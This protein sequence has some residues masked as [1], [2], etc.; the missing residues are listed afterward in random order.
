MKPAGFP[1]IFKDMRWGIF[2][3]VALAGSACTLLVDTS[4]LANGAGTTDGGPEAAATVDPLHDAGSEADVFADAEAPPACPPDALLCEDFENGLG[5]FE[6]H[7]DNG[8]VELATDI[9]HGGKTA[10]RATSNARDGGSNQAELRFNLPKAIANGDTVYFRV[11]VYFPTPLV[12]ESTISK[13]RTPSGTSTDDIN[14]KIDTQGHFKIDADNAKEGP[15]L[16]GVNVAPLARWLCVD[17]SA[18]FGTP[19]HELLDVDGTT[20]IDEDENN[21]PPAGID[22]IGFGFVAA[23]P[24]KTMTV[25]FDDVIVSKTH[26]GCP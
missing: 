9:V 8:V 7:S 25:L 18:R 13:W 12:P 6:V 24:T 19:G 21:F 22:E 15:E 14:L 1:A 3:A 16:S 10:F 5:K 11:Y 4:D 23:A 2:G 20:E 26:V 17:W